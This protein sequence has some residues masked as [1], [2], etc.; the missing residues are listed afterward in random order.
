M[1]EYQSKSLLE[2]HNVAVQKFIVAD[3][4]SDADNL[5]KKLSNEMTTN[6]FL[7][8]LHCFIFIL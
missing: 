8:I 7:N 6:I 2:K 4:V 5:G 3:K 1:L